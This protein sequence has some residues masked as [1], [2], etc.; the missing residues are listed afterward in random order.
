M[1]G[2]NPIVSLFEPGARAKRQL[3]K[4]GI[5]YNEAQFLKA[6]SDRDLQ[7]V[8]LFLKGG[9]RPDVRDDGQNTPLIHAAGLGDLELVSLLLANG[10]NAN[11]K[12]QFECTPLTSALT[13]SSKAHRE[14][15]RLLIKNRADPYLEGSLIVLEA[16]FH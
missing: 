4:Y 11:A 8:K 7:I 5:E 9:I 13:K 1:T 15:V 10:A 14:I 2:Y 3:E 6:I 16:F 12:G